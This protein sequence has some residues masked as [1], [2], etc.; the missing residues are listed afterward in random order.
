MVFSS[1]IANKT[2]HKTKPARGSFCIIVRSNGV[3][4]VVGCVLPVKARDL[5]V[6]VGVSTP[7][8]I[9][10]KGEN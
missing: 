1:E 6:I 8:N 3:G 4:G 7:F 9:A 2:M 5:L 10:P